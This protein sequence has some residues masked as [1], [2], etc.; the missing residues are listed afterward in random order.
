MPFQLVISDNERAIL[1]AVM[2][3]AEAWADSE[4]AGPDYGGQTRDTHPDGERIW[5]A[6]WNNQLDLCDRAN[7]A[8][9][10][11]LGILSLARGETH[12]D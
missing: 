7:R 2:R 8:T 6:W 1:H 3:Q 12:R 11:A 4:H 5:K 9:D 10:A